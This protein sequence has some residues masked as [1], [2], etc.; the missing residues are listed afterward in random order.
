[1]EIGAGA[2]VTAL[3]EIT[4]VGASGA[5]ND[6]LRYGAEAT[7]TAGAGDEIGFLKLRYKAPDS[8][9][10][11]LMETPIRTETAYTDLAKAPMDARFAAAVAAFGQKLKGSDHVE[12]SWRE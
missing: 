4:P 5:L 1:G 2:T 11:Q 12:I 7:A 6:P 9:T 3:Y 8:D 10:S